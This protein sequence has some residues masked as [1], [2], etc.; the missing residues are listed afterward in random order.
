MQIK[1]KAGLLLSGAALPHRA[2]S[3]ASAGPVE[4]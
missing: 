1:R 3:F 2:V 4:F